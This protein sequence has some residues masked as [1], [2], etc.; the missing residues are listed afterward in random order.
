MIIV[1]SPPP[2]V[3]TEYSVIRLYFGFGG[4]MLDTGSWMLDKGRNR[5]HRL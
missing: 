1:V 2:E 5:Q 3:V 4:Q